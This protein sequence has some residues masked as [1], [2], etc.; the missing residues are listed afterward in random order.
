MD[1]QSVV[2]TT[3]GLEVRCTGENRAIPRIGPSGKPT[4]AWQLGSGS[5]GKTLGEVVLY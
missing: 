3:N 5:Y 4:T 2:M 1:F